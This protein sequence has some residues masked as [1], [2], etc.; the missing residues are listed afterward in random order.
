MLTHIILQFRLTMKEISIYRRCSS[1]DLFFMK[2]NSRIVGAGSR[3]LS[4]PSIAKIVFLYWDLFDWHI[5]LLFYDQP[6]IKLVKV[7]FLLVIEFQSFVILK[8]KNWVDI[9]HIKYFALQ[10]CYSWHWSWEIKS[11]TFWRSV[12]NL[13][14]FQERQAKGAG[15]TRIILR[16]SL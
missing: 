15:V 5:Y 9:W 12:V 13:I 16:P 3:S 7:S 8:C 2:L 1:I 10:S 14:N 4:L 11:W 6:H